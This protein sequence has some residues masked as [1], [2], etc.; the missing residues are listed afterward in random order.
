[1]TSKDQVTRHLDAHALLH[2]N[3]QQSSLL[4]LQ[5][6]I[7]QH[8]LADEN[9]FMD[10]LVKIVNHPPAAIE[11]LKQQTAELVKDVRQQD[12]AVD[13][14]DLLLQQYS[15]DTHEGVLLMCLAEAL[16]RVPDSATAD[17]LIRDKL[18]VA[19]WK[20]HLGKSDSLL[21]NA[22]T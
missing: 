11:Q 4:E 9:S 2:P 6:Q 22:S 19:D 13:S 17:A 7:T 16:L 18:S 15:L 3:L 10:E 20:Q 8:Y 1:M 5:L 14:I 12:D 21:V